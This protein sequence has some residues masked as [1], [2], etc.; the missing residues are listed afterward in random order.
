MNSKLFIFIKL[1]PLRSL[2]PICCK[3]L[4]RFPGEIFKLIILGLQ[5]KSCVIYRSHK[6]FELTII[7]EMHKPSIDKIPFFEK[8][9]SERHWKKNILTNYRLKWE[10]I[11][12]LQPMIK[13]DWTKMTVLVIIEKYEQRKKIYQ[14]RLTLEIEHLLT[15]LATLTNLSINSL[16]SPISFGFI[17]WWNDILINE[18]QQSESTT[19]H[20]VKIV[21]I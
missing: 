17:L 1:L 2:N 4:I 18:N 14:S 5:K 12:N 19:F 3:K 15:Q 6:R 9:T 7:E 21:K 8:K 20:I 13:N 16:E 10:L 11:L